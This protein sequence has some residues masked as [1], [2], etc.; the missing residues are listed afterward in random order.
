MDA[1]SFILFWFEMENE[2]HMIGCLI[3]L[4]VVTQD[5][6]WRV[7]TSLFSKYSNCDRF[8]IGTFFLIT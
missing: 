4:L 6:T 8:K 2:L 1:C 5:T 7:V 3:C